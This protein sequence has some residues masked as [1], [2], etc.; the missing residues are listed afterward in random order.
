MTLRFVEG[1]DHLA[2][3]SPNFG[4]FI[5]TGKWTAFGNNAASV[6]TQ[7]TGRY[8]APGTYLRVTGGG[9]IAG[10][11]DK[12]NLPNMTTMV[13][14]FAYR[15]NFVTSTPGY[16][17]D[18]GVAQI[19]FQTTGTNQLAVYRGDIGT[20]LGTTTTVIPL[21]TWVYLEFRVLIDPS[22]GTVDIRQDGVSILSLTGLNTRSTANSFVNG[23]RIG[24]N[25]NGSAGQ[26]QDWDDL[27]CL[28]TT[29]SVNNNFLGEV[30]IATIYPTGSSADGLPHTQWT[31]NTGNNFAAVN[32]TTPDGDTTYVSDA[33]VGHI[34]TYA[35]GDLPVAASTI[36]GI[37]YNVVAR[38]D[39]VG[40]RQIA[41]VYR[42]PSAGGADFV[43][44]TGV[45]L[46]SVYTDQ[47]SIV[48][49]NP[50]TASAWTPAAVNAAE[51]GIE[52]VA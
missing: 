27:Y 32:Q 9:F 42:R 2:V 21:N 8:G 23:F 41:P 15:T 44:A 30:R 7:A 5:T 12:L 19:S 10:Y 11:L 6:I 43:G 31:P 1:F 29:G 39:D 38:K 48:E 45:N 4:D 35:F 13:V 51:F 28:D 34:D 14:G 16:F 17:L 26:N 25:H 49:L 22:V 18:S 33:T 20:L 24:Y 47:T 50:D 37:Q 3:A 52:T 46:T 36:F 40:I